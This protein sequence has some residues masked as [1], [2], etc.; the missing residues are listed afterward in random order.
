[1]LWTWQHGDLT[2]L[3]PKEDEGNLA[4]TLRRIKAKCLLL[5]CTTDILFPPEDNE[6]EVKHLAFGEL[7]VLESV[8]GHLAGGGFGPREDAEFLCAKIKEFL[9]FSDRTIWLIERACNFHMSSL[10]I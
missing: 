6:D 9:Q 7:A 3:H 8:W 2:V 1:M 5:P 10:V 4:K